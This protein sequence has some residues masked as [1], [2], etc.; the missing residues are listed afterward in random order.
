MN[1]KWWINNGCLPIMASGTE[2]LRIYWSHNDSVIN[3]WKSSWTILVD[4]NL[5]YSTDI[6]NCWYWLSPVPLD[7]LEYAT[8]SSQAVSSTP[9]FQERKQDKLFIH[10]CYCNKIWKACWK[11]CLNKKTFI[12]YYVSLFFWYRSEACPLGM[13]AAASSIFTSGT[14][15]RGDLVVKKIYGHSP[16]SADSRRAVVSYWRKHV[17]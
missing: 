15:F 1:E 11:V 16:S 6:L 5:K 2:L 12:I 4:T 14:F 9:Y 8:L 17:H 7:I 3:C 13:Q 10:F